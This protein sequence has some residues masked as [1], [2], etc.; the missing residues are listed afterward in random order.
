MIHISRQDVFSLANATSLLGLALTIYGAMHITTLHG[1]L[2]LGLGRFIDVFDG[3]IARATHTSQLGAA[4]DAT[5]DKIGIAALVTAAWLSHIAP[6]WLLVY[7][8]IQNILN[9]IVS[10][11]TSARGG[12]PAAS[13]MGKYA[14]FL[15]NVSLGCYALGYTTDINFFGILGLVVGLI[16]V[17]WAV[18][19]TYGYAVLLP[20]RHK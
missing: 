7:I 15:Q 9:I 14:M 1:V 8:L 6:Y 18:R 3:K 11:L 20:Q 13:R 12:T 19:A 17:Y 4:V 5:C 2:L 16:S 10:A